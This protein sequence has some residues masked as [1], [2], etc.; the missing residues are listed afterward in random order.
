[1]KKTKVGKFEYRVRCARHGTEGHRTHAYHIK[2][3]ERLVKAIAEL[4]DGWSI[5]GCK[6]WQSEARF[7]TEWTDDID[8]LEVRSLR[9]HSRPGLFDEATP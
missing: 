7:V 4:N 5:D 1:M 6:P 3:T 8:G 2:K 9:L